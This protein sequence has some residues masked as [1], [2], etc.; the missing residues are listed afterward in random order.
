MAVQPGFWE[1]QLNVYIRELRAQGKVMDPATGTPPTVD[2][3]PDEDPIYSRLNSLMTHELGEEFGPG[4]RRVR[5]DVTVEQVLR[6][7]R[8]RQQRIEA[9]SAARAKRA[10]IAR[11]RA[12]ARELLTTARREHFAARARRVKFAAAAIGLE[13]A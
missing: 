10:R 7:V 1:R 2:Y 8:E 4:V 12:D 5:R 3:D 13:P 11:V 6:P 9:R